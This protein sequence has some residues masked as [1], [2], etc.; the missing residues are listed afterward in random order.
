MSKQQKQ[1]STSDLM[2]YA[3]LGAQ[4]FVSL[5]LAVFVGYKLDRWM[6]LSIPVFVW[7]LPFVVLCMM[8]YK[9]IKETSKKNKDHEKR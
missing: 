4:I 7:L 3:G 5:G 1:T 8:I 6:K 9:L 2:R